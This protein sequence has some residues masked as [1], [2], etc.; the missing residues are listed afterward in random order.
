M[1]GVDPSRKEDY[2]DSRVVLENECV[3]PDVIEELGID[4]LE[5]L[6]VKVGVAARMVMELR[7]GGAGS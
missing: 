4:R 3:G 2:A 1:V 5:K 7:K 6:G